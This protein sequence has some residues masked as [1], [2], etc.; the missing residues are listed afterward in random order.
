MHYD[1]DRYPDKQPDDWYDTYEGTIVGHVSLIRD[2]LAI[3]QLPKLNGEDTS[4]VLT[5]QVSFALGSWDNGVWV[6][7]VASVSGVLIGIDEASDIPCVLI[8]DYELAE[9]SFNDPDG[10]VIVDR[11]ELTRIPL[12]T[13]GGVSGFGEA[14]D[15]IV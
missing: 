9:E 11:G 5:P 14:Q 15:D 10:F 4:A 12:D 2:M 8:G 6:D 1:P 3:N 13:V 7:G